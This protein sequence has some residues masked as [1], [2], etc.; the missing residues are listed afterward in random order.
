[1]TLQGGDVNFTDLFIKPN[2]SADLSQIGGSVIGLSSELDTAADVDLRGRFAKTAPVEIR[3][4]V[5]PLIRN[6]FLDLKANVRDIEL[7]P[8]SPYSGKYVGYAIEKGK[9]SFAVEYKIENRKLAAQNQLVLNQLTF[10]DKIESPDAIKLPVLLAV[11]LLKDRNGVID[12]NLPVSGSLDDPKF[13]IGGIIWRVILNLLE[14]AIT[15]PFA[16]IGNLLGGG[17]GEE[18]SYLEFE[19]GRAL[20][21]P[22]SQDKLAKLQTA[23]VERPGLK[24]D[25]SGRYDAQTDREGLRQHRF[26]Q[27]V[28]AQKL[29]DMVKKGA[30]VKSVDE[31]QIDPAEYEKYLERAYKAAKFPKPRNAIG[32][33]KDLP[34]EEMEKL[35]LTNTQVTDDDLLELANQRAQAAK[36][37]LTREEKVALERVFLLAPKPADAA[38][39]GKGKASRVEFS[40]K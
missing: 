34:R 37:A 40:L 11:A 23:L 22:E 10:G 35:M 38:A 5:N 24:L 16:L 36:D 31:V 9:M 15:A 26:E 20:I 3:G 29:K 27:Q 25:I 39:E 6:L 8:F 30:T 21:T 18:L 17:A 33:T 19:P 14:K 12:V 7:G 1:V 2:Y 32:L 13:S 28:K 4:R